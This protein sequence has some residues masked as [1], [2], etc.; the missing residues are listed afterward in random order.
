MHNSGVEKNG[1]N[2]KDDGN[3]G[4]NGPSWAMIVL[5]DRCLVLHSQDILP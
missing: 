2:H 4:D 5:M 3:D 1:I